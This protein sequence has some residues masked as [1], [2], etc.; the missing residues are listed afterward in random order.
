MD[1]ERRK[2]CCRNRLGYRGNI[3]H[4]SLINLFSRTTIYGSAERIRFTPPFRVYDTNDT[5]G[6]DSFGYSLL[7]PFGYFFIHSDKS[8]L[9]LAPRTGSTLRRSPTLPTQRL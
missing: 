6:E 7:D 4:G 8:F 2:R 1:K 9:S 5:T 3:I